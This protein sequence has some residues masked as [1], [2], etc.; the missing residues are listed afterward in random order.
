[1]INFLL[2]KITGN[3]GHQNISDN[4]SIKPGDHMVANWPRL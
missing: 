1:M 2:T 4:Q 3:I